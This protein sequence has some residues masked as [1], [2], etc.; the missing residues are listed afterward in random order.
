MNKKKFKV[1][2]YKSKKGQWQ[3]KKGLKLKR[4]QCDVEL[5]P[6]MKNWDLLSMGN[7][8][9]RILKYIFRYNIGIVNLCKLG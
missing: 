6:D 1:K 5:P 4:I 3:T 2:F 7:Q 8:V 9:G